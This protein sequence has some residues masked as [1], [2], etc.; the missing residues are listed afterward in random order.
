MQVIV[1]TTHNFSFGEIS[2]FSYLKRHFGQVEIKQEFANSAG[3]LDTANT[4]RVADFLVA[5]NGAQ[6][7]VVSHKPH[8]YQRAGCLVGVY[9]LGHTSSAV[10][11]RLPLKGAVEDEGIEKSVNL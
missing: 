8:M 6:Y 2:S 11:L 3:A 9:S 7:I 1:N 5:Q 4:R 10:T